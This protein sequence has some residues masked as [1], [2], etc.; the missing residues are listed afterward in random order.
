MCEI[1]SKTV[2]KI[3]QNVI[4]N[5][6]VIEWRDLVD[7]AFNKKKNIKYQVSNFGGV[8]RVYKNGA[9]SLLTIK[10]T[11]EGVKT[12][13]IQNTVGNKC[14][15]GV[16]NINELVA[17]AFINDEDSKDKH[18]IYRN[19]D[20][21]NP[22]LYNLAYLT[23]SEYNEY[24]KTPEMKTIPGFSNY[25][26]SQCGK[27]LQ[28]KTTGYFFKIPDTDY[29]QVLLRN[30]K[31]Q[32]QNVQINRLIGITF[33]DNPNPKKFNTVHHKDQNTE[34]NHKDNLEWADMKT[35]NQPENKTIHP[36]NEKHR[37]PVQ[38]C[39]PKTGVVIQLHSSLSEACEWLFDNGYTTNKYVTGEV[40]N[41]CKNN[42]LTRFKFKW[43]Y[44]KL[45]DLENENWRPLDP[46]HIRGRNGYMISDLGRLI[47]P[48]GALIK[49]HTGKSKKSYVRV[50][51]GDNHYQL[52][53]LVAL[54]FL[55][56][57]K[58]KPLVNHKN[59]VK[60]DCRVYN[61]EWVTHS[62]NVRHAFET[63]LNPNAKKVEFVNDGVTT[64]YKSA[65]D[66]SDKL[67]MHVNSISLLCMGK[68]KNNRKYP[69]AT[70][71]YV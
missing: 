42:N 29:K 61:L 27:L 17:N 30:D 46:K 68:Q 7:D 44:V 69:N 51:L 5:N 31:K 2:D 34:N 20:V 32:R 52:H 10:L 55:P 47:N 18:L 36:T 57:F 14:E 3:M 56:N 22:A 43:K 16:F 24:T 41:A 53:I 54:T 65:H 59:G 28:N 11:N 19:G 64:I 25:Q 1:V 70:F 71:R 35:Q 9:M 60:T 45:E 21:S 26:I 58:G 39:D 38:R 15:K 6:S 8:R 33:V 13:M 63:G 66:A 40:I 37:R 4:K 23:E 67:Q 50:G 49:G 12:I 62:E 48:H